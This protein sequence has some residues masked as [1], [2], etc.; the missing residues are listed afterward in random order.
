M[1][2][3]SSDARPALHCTRMMPACNRV[4]LNT[5]VPGGTRGGKD[6]GEGRCCCHVGGTE[7]ETGSGVGEARGRK[8]EESEGGEVRKERVG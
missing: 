1:P 2:C 3:S 4:F 5:Q 6:Q 7:G 8:D